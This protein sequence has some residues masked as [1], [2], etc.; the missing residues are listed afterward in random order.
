MVGGVGGYFGGGVYFAANENESSIKSL[1]KGRGLEC[2]LWM[3]NMYIIKTKEERN[4]FINTICDMESPY[5]FPIDVMQK[6][7]LEFGYDSVWGVQDTT[8][9][10][11]QN[12]ILRTGDEY[13]VYSAD[14]VQPIKGYAIMHH[15]ISKFEKESKPIWTNIP[16]RLDYDDPIKPTKPASYYVL[17]SEEAHVFHFPTFEEI[18]SAFPNQTFQNGDIVNFSHPDYEFTETIVLCIYHETKTYREWM[19]YQSVM[20]DDLMN[21]WINDSI[22]RVFLPQAKFMPLLGFTSGIE[23]YMHYRNVFTKSMEKSHIKNQIKQYRFFVELVNFKRESLSLLDVIH[24]S[25][26]ED[27]EKESA[28]WLTSVYKKIPMEIRNL[29]NLTP[30]N[31]SILISRLSQFCGIYTDGVHL[32]LMVSFNEIFNEHNQLYEIKK[33]LLS[34]FKTDSL[35]NQLEKLI[36]KSGLGLFKEWN[37]L[38]DIVKALKTF[39]ENTFQESYKIEVLNGLNSFN[40]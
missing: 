7:L 29:L 6:L 33:G 2:R 40:A 15:N 20:G 35:E 14:Q 11:E 9:F 22:N 4:E 31:I 17:N 39:I 18:K 25:L 13:V 24:L 30:S 27:S 1:H 26:K 16:L 36:G 5:E 21:F 19:F 8:V 23:F 37:A 38:N 32:F 28:K 3:G 10:P 12:R 34:I